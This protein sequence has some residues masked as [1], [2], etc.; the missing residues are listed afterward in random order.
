[1]TPGAESFPAHEMCDSCD[2]GAIEKKRLSSQEIS[3]GVVHNGCA[4]DD[5]EISP[6]RS[7][8]GLFG[9]FDSY[10]KFFG[11]DIIRIQIQNA[12]RELKGQRF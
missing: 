9:T 7:F 8:T 3:H 11:A 12:Q 2:S 10:L 6:I 4:R 5:E 1:M